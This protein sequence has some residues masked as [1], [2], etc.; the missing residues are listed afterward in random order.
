MCINNKY[1]FDC[2]Y[3]ST[4]ETEIY[5]FDYKNFEEAKKENELIMKNNIKY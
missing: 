3:I 2:K 1:I 4:D 5:E